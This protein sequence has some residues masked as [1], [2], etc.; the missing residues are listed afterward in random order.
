MKVLRKLFPH[1]VLTVLLTVVWLLL[2][3]AYS[4]NSLLFGAFLGVLIPFITSPYWPN[5]PRVRHPLKI[6]EYFFIV[7]WDIVVANFVVANLILFRRNADLKPAW[8]TVPLDLRT[9]EAITV[10]AG[11]ITL[12]PGTVSSD[13]SDEGHAILVHCLN[14]PD[15]QAVCDEIKTRYERRLKEIFE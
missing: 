7:L 14:A 2:V 1:P 13:I 10:L 15:P 5:M 8:V 4:I 12:T 6:I 9:P 11:T 3:N